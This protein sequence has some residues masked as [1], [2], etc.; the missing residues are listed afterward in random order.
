MNLEQILQWLTSSDG[1]ALIVVMWFVSWG[2]EELDWWQSLESKA[3]SLIILGTAA[4]IAL[5]AAALQTRPDW[6]AA[7]DPFFQPVYYVLLAWL[8][9][10][11]VHRVGQA[12]KGAAVS[13]DVTVVEPTV[14]VDKVEVP[15][16]RGGSGAG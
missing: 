2:L 5:L 16:Y 9:T 12:L 8:A 11:T 15:A 1:G 3:R 4:A 13:G 10:Q 7:I 6:V 14:T